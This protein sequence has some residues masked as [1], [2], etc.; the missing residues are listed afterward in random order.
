MADHKN[1]TYE[2]VLRERAERLRSY[3][4]VLEERAARFG[5]PVEEAEGSGKGLRWMERAKKKAEAEGLSV[6]EYLDF[7]AACVRAGL[8]PTPECLEADEVECYVLHGRLRKPRLEHVKACRY[9]AGLVTGLKPMATISDLITRA[10]Q[11]IVKPVPKKPIT[12]P[13]ITS[14]PL[15]ADPALGHAPEKKPAFD[16]GAALPL[17]ITE[18]FREFGG[19]IT[20]GREAALAREAAMAGVDFNNVDYDSDIGNA[21]RSIESVFERHLGPEVTRSALEH[22][23][24][25]LNMAVFEILHERPVL[26]ADE[27]MKCRDAIGYLANWAPELAARHRDRFLWVQNNSVGVFQAA[28]RATPAPAPPVMEPPRAAAAFG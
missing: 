3:K 14:P 18:I 23:C 16:F 8:D 21:A 15:A 5:V 26:A 22:M 9:C 19:G 4:N 17:L 10:L 20:V 12:A 27:L 28:A 24:G 13:A 25:G 6:E 11:E 2:D 7:Q 1:Q